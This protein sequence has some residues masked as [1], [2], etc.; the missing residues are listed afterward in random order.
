MVPLVLVDLVM[1]IDFPASGS[2]GFCLRRCGCLSSYMA[3]EGQS[4]QLLVPWFGPHLPYSFIWCVGYF[5]VAML[6]GLGG[7]GRETERYPF[8]AAVCL[9]WLCGPACA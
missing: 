5:L 9:F 3:G 1:I 2:G 7:R 4:D 6:L 8:A